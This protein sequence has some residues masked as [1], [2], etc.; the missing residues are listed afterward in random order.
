MTSISDNQ[1]K[2]GRPATGSDPMWGV[3][4]TANQREL[5]D[6][7]ADRNGIARAEAVRRLVAAGLVALEGPA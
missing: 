1:K 6:G 7:Y 3:R 2:R 5:I 4:F